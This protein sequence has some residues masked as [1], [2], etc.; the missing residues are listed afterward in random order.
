MTRAQAHSINGHRRKALVA[1]LVV[2]VHAWLLSVRLP[3]APER[4]APHASTGRVTVLL[5]APTDVP[6]TQQPVEPRRNVP[7]P[8]R[9]GARPRQ[10]AARSATPWIPDNRPALPAG[11]ET[12]MPEAP[13]SP[14]RGRGPITPNLRSLQVAPTLAERAQPRL[15]RAPAANAL[16]RGIESS[17]RSDCREAY[18]GLGHPI[19]GIAALVRDALREDGCKW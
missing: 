8:R 16:Q 9:T 12:T 2:G 10:A 11:P 19:I 17:A 7:P 5:I 13:A 6:S 3:E 1:L 15:D 4:E 18:A 14:A